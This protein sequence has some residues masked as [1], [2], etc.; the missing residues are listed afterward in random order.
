MKIYKLLF[1]LQIAVIT[2]ITPAY[3]QLS[4]I[5][6]AILGTEQDALE[7]IKEEISKN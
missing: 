5:T 1:A 3:G 4:K 6:D 7:G 2:A